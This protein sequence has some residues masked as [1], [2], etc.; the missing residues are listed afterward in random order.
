M[1][2]GGGGPDVVLK[3]E[4]RNDGSEGG[5]AIARFWW[6]YVCM[7]LLIPRLMILRLGSVYNPQVE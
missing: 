2:H 7:H 5:L 1:P 6:N 4:K 3:F